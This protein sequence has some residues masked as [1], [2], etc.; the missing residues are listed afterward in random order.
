VKLAS[1]H[2]AD[3]HVIDFTQRTYDRVWDRT[4]IYAGTCTACCAIVDATQYKFD[5]ISC[6]LLAAVLIAALVQIQ[7]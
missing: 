5:L 2:K 3:Q 1:L 6:M 4:G 7:G